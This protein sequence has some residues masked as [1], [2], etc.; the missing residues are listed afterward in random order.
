MLYLIGLGILVFIYF[1]EVII[2][3]V[4]IINVRSYFKYLNQDT[5]NQLKIKLG[6][7]IAFVLLFMLYRI[8]YFVL[9]QFEVFDGLD[10]IERNE[11]LK[12]T[13]YVSVSVLIGLLIFIN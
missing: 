10:S 8:M 1:V 2:F 4:V 6:L 9:L 13:Y 7:F 5:Y 12:F 11:L 3:A